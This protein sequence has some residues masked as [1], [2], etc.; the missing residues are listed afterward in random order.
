MKKL[1]IL[2]GCTVVLNGCATMSKNECLGADDYSRWTILGQNDGLEGKAPQIEKRGQSCAKHKIIIDREAYKVGYRKGIAA[3]CQPQNILSLALQGKGQ[4][5]GAWFLQ[6]GGSFTNCP[7]ERQEELRS[8]YN[9]GNN[10][11][12]TKTQLDDLEKGIAS[13][14]SSLKK[15]DLKQE[16]R[17]YFYSKIT[18][19][20]EL[21]PSARTNFEEAK[22]NLIY[23][24]RQNGL[25]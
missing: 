10:Y 3:Y 7:L 25:N 21:L 13:A 14:K 11:Y 5:Q 15:N 23:F 8:Y 17:N 1:L 22:R 20:T 2:I 9:V 19:N 12:Q 6:N 4:G 16:D 18:E 24:K